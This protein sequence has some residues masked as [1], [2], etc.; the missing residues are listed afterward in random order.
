[1]EGVEDEL[2]AVVFLESGIADHVDAFSFP[3]RAGLE[4]LFLGHYG[5][6]RL[7]ALFTLALPGWALL[8][9]RAPRY[10][11]A[12][13]L[14]LGCAVLVFA[15]YDWEGDRFLWPALALL[16]P[17]LAASFAGLLRL[18]R[19]VNERARRPRPANPHSP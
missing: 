7:F 10:V 3:L 15:K 1:M 5:I 13:V 16:V 12:S 9:R 18:L 4:R 11:A 17:A 6:A 8:G 14:A 19:A 2:Q